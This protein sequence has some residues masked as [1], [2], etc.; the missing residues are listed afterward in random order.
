MKQK[1]NTHCG[2][3]AG[4]LVKKELSIIV[5]VFNEESSLVK[6][7]DELMQSSKFFSKFELIVINDG[8]QDKSQNILESLK[9]R[10]D[11]TLINHESN[12]GYGASLKTGIVNSNNECVA[13][14]DADGQHSVD[15]L[16]NL[17]N[18]SSNFDV[19]I[20]F[21]KSQNIGPVWRIP[22]K[23]ILKIFFRHIVKD[24]VKDA[25]S[26]LRIWKKRKIQRIMIF[27]SDGFSFSATSLLMAYFLNFGVKWSPIN[28]KER[29][30]GKSAFNL[31]KIIRIIAKLTKI[32]FYFSP[33]RILNIF[34]YGSLITGI[35][36]NTLSYTQSGSSSIKGLLALLIGLVIFLNG[37][38][39]E[40]I[41]K[42]E[43]NII[44]NSM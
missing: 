7:I 23:Q 30:N 3:G 28:N 26:G 29:L 40:F 34:I 44:M 25:T 12:K 18:E 32:T 4:Q 14:F 33:M 6:T 19:S 9:N 11:F 38:I 41:S 27:C 22:L 8:S 1:K 31:V 17:F 42:V 13:F 16:I 37:L 39:I 2:L 36:L 10:Y 35:L 20:G 15:D 43:K 21:R 24:E 5:P